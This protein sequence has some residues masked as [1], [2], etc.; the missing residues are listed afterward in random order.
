[1][2]YTRKA[3]GENKIRTHDERGGDLLQILLQMQQNRRANGSRRNR[4]KLW[5]A[6]KKPADAGERDRE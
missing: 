2:G 3:A 6:C 1:M 4:P 5:P